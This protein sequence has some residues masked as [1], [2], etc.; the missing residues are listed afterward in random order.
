MSLPLS[1]LRII[2]VEQY[3]AGP[4]GT[5]QLADLGADVIKVEDPGVGGDVGRYVPPFAEGED[6]LF[7]ETFNRN[8]RSIS[9]DL[10]APEGRAAFEK[11][12]GVSDVVFSNLRGDQ[13]ER[14]GLTFEQLRHL[15]PRIVCCS[16]SGFGMSGPRAKEGAYDYTIQGMAGWASL[17]GEPDGPPGKSALSLVDFSGGYVAAIAILAGVMRARR[18]GVGADCDLSLFETAL[19]ELT[20]VG[21]WQASR[22]FTP[23]RTGTAHASMVPFQTFA[24]MDGSIVIACPKQGLWVRLCE[25]LERP[26]WASDPRFSGFAERRANAAELVALIEERLATRPVAEWVEV[27]GARGVPCAPVNSVE[28]A[29]ADPQVAHRDGIWEYEHPVLGTVRQ[30]ASPLRMSDAE[31]PNHRAPHRGEHTEVVLRE[32]CGYDDEAIARLEGEKR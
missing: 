21:T 3:G 20:Y 18:D 8:K 29:L 5:L 14:L 2:A 28:Q 10:K 19:A 30:A 6:S 16:L 31:L 32:L 22:G 9:L 24:A 17:T 25:G 12:V 13:P 23:P 7:F 15:N 4:W 27:L 11:L 26:E 1:D